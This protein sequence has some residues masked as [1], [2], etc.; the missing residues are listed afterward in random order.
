M[1]PMSWMWL[2]VAGAQ[3]SAGSC[4]SGQ[5]TVDGAVQ[6][7][8]A[9]AL[10]GASSGAHVVVCPGTYEGTFVAPAPIVLEAPAG[11]HETILDAKGA[12]TV[13]TLAAGS[14]VEG[15]TIRG[16]QT[17]GNGG[18]VSIT[19]VGSTTV[20]QCDVLDNV[21]AVSGGGLYAPEG[22]TVVAWHSRFDHNTAGDGGGIAFGD[23]YVFGGVASEIDLL[24]SSVS[25]NTAVGRP[26]GTSFRNARGGGLAMNGGDVTGGT[27]EGN[28]A[29]ERVRETSCCTIRTPGLGGG[30]YHDEGGSLFFVEVRDN[31]AEGNG[32]GLLVNGLG[33]VE[34]AAVS[35]QGNEAIDANGGGIAVS[36]AV[37]SGGLDVS[38][39]GLVVHDNEALEGRGGGVYLQSASFSDFGVSWQG[40]WV[41]HNRAEDGGGLAIGGGDMDVSGVFVG[42]NEASEDGGG[43]ATLSPQSSIFVW[44]FSLNDMWFVGNQA[45]GAGGGFWGGR[46]M[47]LAD[48][49]FLDNDAARGGGLALIGQRE[50]R[51][52]DV[53]RYELRDVVVIDNTAQ[54]IGGGVFQEQRATVVAQTSV[55]AANEAAV[56]GGL[57]LQA[58]TLESVDS[59]WGL[60]F[61]NEPDDVWLVPSALGYANF[62]FGESFVCDA[63][64]CI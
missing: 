39:F 16:G 10:A 2:G 53:K 27:F 26:R 48:T 52:P 47:T 5:V 31:I 36:N 32:G 37:S 4:P 41:T 34:L 60:T 30:I 63:L 38:T 20:D 44:T 42:F 1:N 46:N 11:R 61:D 21:A 55:F 24:W 54:V 29:L 33:A 6:V 64:V 43:F 56:G 51:A 45:A 40:G 58:G 8:L 17:D 19:G 9:A 13:L 62:G 22:S 28:R 23:T 12:G 49:W 25:H 3:A 15:F 14:W 18:G 57:A 7:D 50:S 35:V 59:D